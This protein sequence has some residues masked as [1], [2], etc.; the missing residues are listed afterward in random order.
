MWCLWLSESCA[1]PY[2]KTREM[3]CN[4]VVVYISTE[5]RCLVQ[6]MCFLALSAWLAASSLAAVMTTSTSSATHEHVRHMVATSADPLL[7][8]KFFLT[9]QRLNRCLNRCYTAEGATQDDRIC[10]QYM[11]KC[12]I[13]W[14][15]FSGTAHSVSYPQPK[16]TALSHTCQYYTGEELELNMWHRFQLFKYD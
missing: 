6:V 11:R 9:C 4:F 7:A 2:G 1:L 15:L 16:R 12:C 14:L 3:W 10:L 13:F 5:L 8:V